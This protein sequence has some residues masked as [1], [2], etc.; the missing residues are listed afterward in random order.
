VFEN[1]ISYIIRGLAFKIHSKIGIGLLESAYEAALA[2]E[3]EKSRL[4]WVT[5]Q[6]Q[7]L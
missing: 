7:H 3:P 5:Y 1:D 2:Y 4:T 6:F